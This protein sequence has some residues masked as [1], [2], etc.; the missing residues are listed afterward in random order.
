MVNGYVKL[1][2]VLRSE[3]YS[4]FRWDRGNCLDS[5]SGGS[6]YRYIN[7][8]LSMDIV[9]TNNLYARIYNYIYIKE[10]T[11]GIKVLDLRDPKGNKI[12]DLSLKLDY[13]RDSVKYKPKYVYY[14]GVFKLLMLDILVKL[15]NKDK[16]VTGY[17]K[18]LM[19]N[20]YGVVTVDN[21]LL[22]TEEEVRILK[23]ELIDKVL[24]AWYSN[25]FNL[26]CS[27]MGTYY[28]ELKDGYTTYK[29]N[30]TYNDYKGIL[31]LDKETLRASKRDNVVVSLSVDKDGNEV[32][33]WGNEELVNK[34]LKVVDKAELAKDLKELKGIIKEIK[35]VSKA[36][37]KDVR[38]TVSDIKK[39][40]DKIDL[41]TKYL[42]DF[43]GIYNHIVSVFF[44]VY[45]KKYALR[46]IR[47]IDFDFYEDIVKGLTVSTCT[48]LTQNYNR[49]GFIPLSTNAL[50]RKIRYEIRNL[51]DLLENLK[52]D[53]FNYTSFKYKIEWN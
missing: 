43:V 48:F 21:S 33:K 18:C 11:K 46:G 27:A 1:G 34:K 49:S 28:E 6:H 14:T 36:K 31:E 12:C 15:Y 42:Q 4:N 51:R 41:H 5:L 16:E 22:V 19:D 10:Y 50:Q 9:G 32:F 35:G 52:L 24:G 23:S 40:D 26:M 13:D 37:G 44:K 53:R 39:L 3:E 8:Y 45:A 38:I 7:A 17:F 47:C 29:Y 30:I 25:K 2:D 20:Y